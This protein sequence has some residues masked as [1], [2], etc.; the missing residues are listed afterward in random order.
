MSC[1][2]PHEQTGKTNTHGKA[3]ASFITILPIPLETISITAELH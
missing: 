3:Q 1:S 2:V